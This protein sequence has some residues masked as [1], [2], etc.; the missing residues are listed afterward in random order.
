MRELGKSGN[1]NI[2]LAKARAIADDNELEEAEQELEEIDQ[3]WN[4]AKARLEHLTA[5]EAA[6]KADNEQVPEA[7]TPSKGIRHPKGKRDGNTT[8]GAAISSY[9]GYGRSG[10]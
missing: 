4:E 3:Q 8:G 2:E 6:D 7:P 10:Q 9:A 1:K 5:S